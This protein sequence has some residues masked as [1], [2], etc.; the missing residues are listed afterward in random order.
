MPQA[1]RDLPTASLCQQ[2][3]KQWYSFSAESWRSSQ[4]CTPL[5]SWTGEA[6]KMETTQHETSGNFCHAAK[7]RNFKEF[8]GPLGLRP[9]DAG[10]TIP[11]N[12]RVMYGSNYRKTS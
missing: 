1:L 7:E 12:C 11:S 3:L 5:D 6:V 4:C 8:L 2:L 9:E 10:S